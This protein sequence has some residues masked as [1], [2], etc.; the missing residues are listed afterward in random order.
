MQDYGGAGQLSKDTEELGASSRPP[1]L[2]NATLNSNVKEGIKKL[3][4]VTIGQTPRVDLIPE[5]RPI[6]GEGVQVIER[7]ALDGLSLKEVGAFYPGKDDDVLITRMADGT[8]VTV[9]EKYIY[10]RLK[11]Q[12]RNLASLGVKTILIACAGEFPPI[13][14]SSFIVY[15]QRVL[16]HVVAS[17]AQGLK[18]G[19]LIPDKLQVISAQ[20]RWSTAA[21][22][23][24]VEAA[25]PYL[26]IQQVVSAADSLLV[27]QVD[28]V[29]MDC[30][31]YTLGMKDLVSKHIGKPVLLT[32]SITAKVVSELL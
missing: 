25:S 4:I 9:A 28:I 23:V 18:L 10:P 27:S 5:I 17:L 24:V 29:V 16:H 20:K 30:M 32:R 14:S 13:D 2:T 12:V 6:L 7:G 11:D 3:G 1:V 15:P 21:A 26:D 31:G 22:E 19:V 8:S